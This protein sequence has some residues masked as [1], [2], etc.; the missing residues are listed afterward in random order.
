[1]SYDRELLE[2][3][4]RAP[5]LSCYPELVILLNKLNRYLKKNL[6]RD[7]KLGNMC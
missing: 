6:F 2:I 1:M 5:V 7:K 4:I 3:N